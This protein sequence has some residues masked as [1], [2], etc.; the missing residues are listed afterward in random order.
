MS[1]SQGLVSQKAPEHPSCSKH[2]YLTCPELAVQQEMMAHTHLVGCNVEGASVVLGRGGA[3]CAGANAAGGRNADD[4]DKL[5]N[6]LLGL[7]SASL[8]S[9][10]RTKGG[11]VFLLPEGRRVGRTGAVGLLWGIPA[12]TAPHTGP[13]SSL[14]LVDVVTLLLSTGGK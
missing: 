5:L 9:G 12:S 8:G 7:E 2:S 1:L 11:T 10:R 3:L 14:N 4:E 6:T 13:S